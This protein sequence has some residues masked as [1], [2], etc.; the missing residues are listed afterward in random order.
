MTSTL[1]WQQIKSIASSVGLAFCLAWGVERT[2]AASSEQ[3]CSVVID[4]IALDYNHAGGRSVPQLRVRF[5]NAAGKRVT[6]VKFSLSLLASGGDA[7]LYPYD[8]E[9]SGGLETH[10]KK[11]FTWDLVPEAVDMHRA[12]ETVFVQKVEFADETTWVDDSSESCAFK[13]DFHAQ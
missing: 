2:A 7:H 12:G 3:K 9:Y 10:T 8:L 4:Q 13:V 6:T 11:D 1:E 5:G